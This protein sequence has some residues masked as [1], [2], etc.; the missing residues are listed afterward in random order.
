MTLNLAAPKLRIMVG[1][2]PNQQDWSDAYIRFETGDDLRSQSGWLKHRATLVLKDRPENPGG[3]HALDTR[4]PD[5]LAIWGRGQYVTIDL[6]L[7]TGVWARHARGRLRVLSTPLPVDFETK[8]FTVNLGCEATFRDSPEQKQTASDIANTLEPSPSQP[9]GWQDMLKN[10]LQKA[11]FDLNTVLADI[12]AAGQNYILTTPIHDKSLKKSW[13]KQA[14]EMAFGTLHTLFQDNDGNIQSLDNTINIRQTPLQT[15]VLGCGDIYYYKEDDSGDNA[16]SLFRGF[17][18]S[19]EVIEMWNSR[20]T[21]LKQYGDAAIINPKDQGRI[22][23]QKIER[24]DTTGD[25]FREVAEIITE[26]TGLVIPKSKN[27][28]PIVSGTSLER[29]QFETTKEGK[30][31]NRYK[32]EQMLAGKALSQL[33][34][35]LLDDLPTNTQSPYSAIP[36]NPFSMITGK[37]SNVD[38]TYTPE[39]STKGIFITELEPRG[40]IAPDIYFQMYKKDGLIGEPSGLSYSLIDNTEWTEQRPDEWLRQR[41]VMLPA[42]RSLKLEFDKD[43]TLSEQL[44]AQLALRGGNYK[45]DVSSD[46]ETQPPS[47]NRKTPQYK[48]KTKPVQALS[49]N[50]PTG[51]EAGSRQDGIAIPYVAEGNLDKITDIESILKIGRKNGQKI[52]FELDDWWITNPTP[53]PIVH[54]EEPDGSI[55]IFM[56]DAVQFIHEVESA[57]VSALGIWLGTIPANPTTENP[58]DSIWVPYNVVIPLEIGAAA[59]IDIRQIDYALTEI[60]PLEIGAVESPELEIIDLPSTLFPLEFGDSAIDL[61]FPVMVPLEFGD[62]AIDLHFPVM[63][64]LEFAIASVLRFG[65]HP[66]VAA[67]VSRIAADGSDPLSQTELA[68][69]DGLVEALESNGTLGLYKA[70]WT[71]PGAIAATQRYNL[72]NPQNLDSAYR[73]SFYGFIEHSSMGVRVIE[74]PNWAGNYYGGAVTY[75]NPETVLP[76]DNGRLAFYSRDDLVNISPTSGAFFMHYQPQSSSAGAWRLTPKIYSSFFGTYSN[77][78]ING[79][80]FANV[81]TDYPS[82]ADGLLSVNRLNAEELHHRRNGITYRT[83][84]EPVSDTIYFDSMGSLMLL[85]VQSQATRQGCAFA[86]VSEGLTESQEL[87]DFNA[88]QDFLSAI[89]RAV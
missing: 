47:V 3:A 1:V 74:D 51:D 72:L 36:I 59:A 33:I 60:V 4:H 8:E 63:V 42:A 48:R 34:T 57:K 67:L 83:D 79:R 18:Y 20:V 86:A 9:V 65:N 13:T 80:A 45:P 39:Q 38:Y 88:I 24:T 23:I 43:V 35:S 6:E 19:F 41:T 44:R 70:I 28:G 81:F 21:I 55:K 78:Q 2:A 50:I 71:F 22:L 69:L 54:I 37:S 17:S 49:L 85:N 46:G 87:A 15:Y 27:T 84:Q 64:P 53:W 58:I 77:S 62:S 40:A 76:V 30:L 61:H 56:I 32:L 25:S 14:G 82:R 10:V 89:G 5:G 66:L 11:Q 31:L 52:V 26:A 7:K 75:L 73:L 16:A 29:F 12:K 68:A